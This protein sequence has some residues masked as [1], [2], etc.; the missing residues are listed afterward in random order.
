MQDHAIFTAI[1]SNSFDHVSDNQVPSEKF[2]FGKNPE[3]ASVKRWCSV[4]R[5]MGLENTLTGQRSVSK[6][7]SFQ[8]FD[9][10]IS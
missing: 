10:S 1:K 9:N 3:H 4:S 7:C 8:I 5:S 6:R 2:A